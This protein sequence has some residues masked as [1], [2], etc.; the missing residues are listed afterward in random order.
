MKRDSKRPKNTPQRP[1]QSGDGRPQKPH[2]AAHS[3][4]SSGQHQG[5]V[6]NRNR[7]NRRSR[8]DKSATDTLYLY[9]LHA[10]R[11]ALENTKR[12]KMRLLATENALQRL[13]EA[14]SNSG[15]SVD[16]VEASS[17]DPLVGRDAVHQ[18]VVLECAP[19]DNLDASELFHLAHGKL[20][21]VLDQVT[22]PHNVGAI[23][24]SAVAMNVDA[25][26]T[27][28]RN[29]AAETGALAKSASG[30]LDMIRLI[31]V[32]NLSKALEE[33]NSFGF[34]TMGL[35]SEGPQDMAATLGDADVS[36]LTLVLGAEGRGLRQKTRETCSH[37]VR[38]DM[39]GQIKS[40]N[41]SNAAVLSLHI[42]ATA[43][44]LRK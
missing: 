10:V 39:P 8:P 40:L 35:D 14:V 33:L 36:Q 9:G 3:G 4:P 11:A 31:E 28:H 38:L 1:R 5:K 41:V 20:I 25:V 29:S 23:L 2:A 37:L 7:P 27:T 18:G 13:G 21:L 32:R 44:R 42:C 6:E 17:L 43:Q 34:L 15:V 16:L 24:R 12:R 26:I 19:L 22:D 30:A